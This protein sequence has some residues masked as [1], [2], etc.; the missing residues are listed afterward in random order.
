MGIAHTKGSRSEATNYPA[1]HLLLIVGKVLEDI[2]VKRLTSHLKSKHPI[3]ARQFSFRKASSV[4]DFSLLLLRD[5]ID[6]GEG[7]AC[8]DTKYYRRL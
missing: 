5:A 7:Q 2:L 8:L 6:Q 4:A 3:S 1:N